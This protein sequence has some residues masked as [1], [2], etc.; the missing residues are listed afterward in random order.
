MNT[1]KKTQFMTLTALLT[2]IA[3]LIPLVM[4]F[5]IVIPPASYT[6]GS[7]VAIFIA[8]FLSPWM[9]I[10][11]IIASSLGFLMAGYTNV[12]VLRAFSHIFFGSL[13]AFYLQKHPQTL[14]NKKSSL[15]FNFVLGLVH[16]IAE[17]L[18]CMIFYASTGTDLKNM[19][20]VL[21]VLVGFGTI[22]H[23]M[24]DYYLALAVYKALRKRR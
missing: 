1:Q 21:F 3:I 4:P 5:K 20:Y 14:D 12:I 13:G 15:I 23:S 19:F 7:H 2:A 18:A 24:V 22:I 6:L 10:F 11:V 16:A 17:V 8:M 9:A